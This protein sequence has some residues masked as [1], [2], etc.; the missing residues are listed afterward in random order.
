MDRAA[1]R[2]RGPEF[3]G[4]TDARV[5]A[6][7]AAA[8][9]QTDTTIFGASAD[10]AIFFLAAHILVSSPTGTEARLKGEG[11][12]SVYLSER[13]RLEAQFAPLLA[14]T[15]GFGGSCGWDPW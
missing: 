6:A 11:F 13:R 7:L 15:L 5:D 12:E 14:A 10:D 4:A 2:A 3:R 9:R 1:F 8:T